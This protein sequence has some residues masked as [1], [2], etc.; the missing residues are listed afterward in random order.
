MTDNHD[1][2]QAGTPAT[3]AVNRLTRLLT[4]YGPAAAAELAI[5]LA[6][7]ILGGKDAEWLFE[8]SPDLG[9]WQ[10]RYRALMTTTLDAAQAA[11]DDVAA[12]AAIE[13]I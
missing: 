10:P 1:I 3:Q 9:K 11:W 8:E 6:I 7:A 13:D 5:N 4:E 2:R 12:Q